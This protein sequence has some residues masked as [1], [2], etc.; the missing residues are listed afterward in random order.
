M[1]VDVIIQRNSGYN[2]PPQASE[3]WKTGV[4]RHKAVRDPK[5]PSPIGVSVPLLILLAKSLVLR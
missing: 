5:L 4:C 3:H 1:L 2:D